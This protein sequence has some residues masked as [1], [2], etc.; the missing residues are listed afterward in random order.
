ME[1]RENITEVRVLFD[2]ERWLINFRPVL[3]LVNFEPRGHAEAA[4]QYLTSPPRCIGMSPR[5]AD[6]AG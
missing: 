2:Y 3:L 5:S 4:L 1:D 6:G